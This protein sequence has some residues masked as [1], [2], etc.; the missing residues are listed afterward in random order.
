LDIL[1][2]VGELRRALL[3]SRFIKR[4]NFSIDEYIRVW[5]GVKST[6]TIFLARL[7]DEQRAATKRRRRLSQISQTSI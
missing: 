3:V 2:V 7:S 5:N 6:R 1:I 4:A